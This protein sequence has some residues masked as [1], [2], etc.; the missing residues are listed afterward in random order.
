MENLIVLRTIPAALALLFSGVT[1]AAD[2]PAPA[3]VHMD[4][5]GAAR[6]AIKAQRWPDAISLLEQAAE[7]SPRN[8]DAFNLLGYAYRKTGVLITAFKHYKTALT[9]DPNHKGAHEYIGEAYLL[10]NDVKRAQLHLKHLERL[11][12]TGCE[13]RDDLQQ[14]IAAAQA[15]KP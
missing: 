6:D 13:E 14:A 15:K 8:A 4:A 3:S 7:R 1:F 9:L 2:L 10:A 11:C 5:L 12:P